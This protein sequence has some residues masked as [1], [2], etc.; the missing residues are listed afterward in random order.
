MAPV[1]PCNLPGCAGNG[2]EKRQPACPIPRREPPWAIRQT[3]WHQVV[4]PDLMQFRAAA[5][6]DSP[7][8]PVR[9]EWN[10]L[11]AWSRS[12]DPDLQDCPGSP[13]QAARCRP[14]SGKGESPNPVSV[15]AMPHQAGHA[16]MRPEA[17]WHATSV[18]SSVGCAASRRA[19]ARISPGCF[20]ADRWCREPAAPATAPPPAAVRQPKSGPVAGTAVAHG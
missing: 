8:Y 1:G 10:R 15:P 4:D 9:T 6:Q 12:R 20:P 3:E 16:P 7:D 17:G 19:R 18:A 5:L 2:S 14:E 13:T 11:T